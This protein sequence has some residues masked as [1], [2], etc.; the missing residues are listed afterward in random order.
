LSSQIAPADG[1]LT[2]ASLVVLL[3]DSFPVFRKTVGDYRERM[4][5]LGLA[6]VE[7]ADDVIGLADRVARYGR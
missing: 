6:A 1:T 2:L 5:A 4:I 3:S 7:D